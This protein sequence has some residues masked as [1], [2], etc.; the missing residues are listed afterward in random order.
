[1]LMDNYIQ[2]VL[3][4]KQSKNEASKVKEEKASKI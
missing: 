3:F 2:M 4:Q 1:M